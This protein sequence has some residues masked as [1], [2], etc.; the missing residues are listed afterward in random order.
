MYLPQPYS[1]A[2]VSQPSA[3]V[4]AARRVKSCTVLSA[5]MRTPLKVPPSSI[6]CAKIARS[7]AVLNSPAW[8]ATPPRA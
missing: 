2:Q 6:I 1:P 4:P 5:M 3:R 8:P 7:L